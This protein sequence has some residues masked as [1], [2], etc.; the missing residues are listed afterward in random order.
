[1]ADNTVTMKAPKSDTT[2][3]VQKDMVEYYSKMGYTKVGVTVTK[4]LSTFG[5]KAKPKIK[6][7]D[8]K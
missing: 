6:K 1:M 5:N 3:I 7:E 8:N 4:P 2:I